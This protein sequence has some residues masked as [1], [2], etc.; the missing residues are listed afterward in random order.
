LAARRVY[1]ESR[2]PSRDFG[3]QGGRF[4]RS[5]P[6]AC[7]SAT[8]AMSLPV[9]RSAFE[10]SKFGGVAGA[11]RRSARLLRFE[12][13]FR[14]PGTPNNRRSHGGPSFCGYPQFCHRRACI[15]RKNNPERS[16]AVMQRRKYPGRGSS[17]LIKV[18]VP[19]RRRCCIPNGWTHVCLC[20]CQ[21]PADNANGGLSIG[22]Q[23][24]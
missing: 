14:F 24:R 5:S 9:Y 13:K 6:S 1:W 15:V 8:R 19:R 3:S 4:E 11:V 10:C 2:V 17:S 7:R 20:R 21:R 18:D 23:S 22:A 16:N 12:F